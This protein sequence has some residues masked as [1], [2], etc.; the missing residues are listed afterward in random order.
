[1][2]AVPGTWAHLQGKCKHWA[3]IHSVPGDT[4]KVTGPRIL[5]LAADCKCC[6]SVCMKVRVTM[7][8]LAST[9][10]GRC[11][12]VQEFLK[13]QDILSPSSKQVALF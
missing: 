2:N 7:E 5:G 9:R 10:N 1:V 3:H 6:L 4:G 11:E 12:L 13:E 8:M